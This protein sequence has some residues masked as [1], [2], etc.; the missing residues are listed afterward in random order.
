MPSLKI[1]NASCILT[2]NSRG[3]RCS[4]DVLIEG[5]RLVQVGGQIET[6]A[7]EVIDAT[8]CV[9]F[10]GLVN[11]HHH[12][13]QTFQRNLP[14]IQD[15]E[16]FPW[17][18]ALYRVWRYLDPETV[19]WSA[20]LGIGELLL[21][22]CTT[23]TDQFY[24]FPKGVD[25]RLIDAEIEAARALGIRFQPCRGSMS[26]GESTG[27]LPPD[28]VV[29]DEE[30][31]LA[32]CERLVGQYHDP[33]P[34]AML[35]IAFAPCSPFSVS[36]GLLR[37]SVTLA[38]RHGVHLHT[39][40]AETREEER[41]CLE[42]F[43]KRPLSYLEEAG[44]SGSDVWFAHSIYLN[45]EE[46]QRIAHAGSK[47]AHC[48]T[49]NMRLGSGV[50]PVPR[51]LELAIDVGLAVDGSASNDS[52]DML[53]EVRNCLLVH[54]LTHGVASM[55]AEQALRLATKGGAAVLGFPEIGTLEKGKAADLA[56]IDLDRIGYAGGLSDPLATLI[57]CGDCHLV[58]TTIV[59]G[60]VVVR[61]GHLVG[62]DEELIVRQANRL[63]R[64]MQEQ[65]GVL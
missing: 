37:D 35:R 52:S 44:W 61:D 21:T 24:V 2:L 28:D 31:I 30:T 62:M 19:Y 13:Y 38:R 23:T 56:M 54:K 45:E 63:S 7:E 17:L 47:V 42:R 59:N 49:S 14:G 53:G 9:V 55:S 16:L 40:L 64:R 18:R 12:L 22:G 34:F 51:M 10:P 25:P 26:L 36:R 32:D 41:F 33:H 57:Y 43:G 11:T 27:G 15:S 4:G 39:H 46:L 8:G 5:N 60:R 3:T 20:L 6:T 48:P 65:A 1:R 58:K 29:Q 50:A